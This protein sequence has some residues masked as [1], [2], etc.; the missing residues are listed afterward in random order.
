MSGGI[1]PGEKDKEKP[2]NQAISKASAVEMAIDYIK[3]LKKTLEETSSKL[4]TAESK[5][6][7]VNQDDTPTSSSPAL[8]VVD[9]TSPA[10]VTTE[11]TTTTHTQT[12]TVTATANG[13]DSESTDTN[14]S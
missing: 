6:A 14:S 1:K 2:A 7:G 13:T 5:L 10:G 9:K 4:V 12:T 3:A 8:T 11:T